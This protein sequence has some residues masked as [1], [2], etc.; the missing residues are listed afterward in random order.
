MLL[1]LI[2]FQAS[3]LAGTCESYAEAEFI[4]EVDGIEAHE[5]SGLAASRT[6]P[7]IFF[8]HDDSGADAEVFSFSL[9]GSVAES[10]PVDGASFID[11]E[12]MAAAPCPAS[13]QERNLIEDCLFIG[14]IGDNPRSRDDIQI[15]VM[16]EPSKGA[17]LQALETWNLT[18][19]DGP[20]D[21]EALL[22]HPGTG[23]ITLISKTWAGT[24]EI[25]ILET[26]P[27]DGESAVLSFQQELDLEDGDAAGSLITGGDWDADGERLALRTYAYLYVWETDPCTTDGHWEVEPERL[28]TTW[29]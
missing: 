3:V 15:Y 7:G 27:E 26:P 18:Y 23:Q 22:V 4:L 19:P 25:F 6:R 5:S 14:D 11:W 1:F 16:A 8:T 20:R 29:E 28:V 21:S 12:D 24:V 9:D 13:I 10:H 17:S 2:G